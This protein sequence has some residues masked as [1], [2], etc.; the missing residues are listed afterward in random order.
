[1]KP[2]TT[3]TMKVKYTD[4]TDITTVSRNCWDLTAE[5]LAQLLFQLMCGAGYDK[6]NALQG[7]QYVLDENTSKEELIGRIINDTEPE[8]T[9]VTT[10][11]A[12]QGW[13]TTKTE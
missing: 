6:S 2:K 7:F 3:I 13:I 8:K 11:L 1:M 9:D 12:E 10:R 4:S 5:D